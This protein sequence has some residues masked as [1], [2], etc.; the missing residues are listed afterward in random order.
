MPKTTHIYPEFEKMLSREKREELLKQHGHVFWF[1]GLSG[2]GKSTLT[3]AVQTALF[4]QGVVTE[5]LDGD[6]IRSGLNKDL[7]FTDADRLEN[8]R[9]IAEVAKLFAQ[10]GVIVLTAFITPKNE[11]RHMARELVGTKDLSEVYVKASFETCASRDPKGL[12]KKV[13]AG[14]VKNFTG[15]DS[16]FEEPAGTD[17]VLDTEALDIHQCVEQLIP[18]ILKK[19]R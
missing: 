15:K 18:F 12:Y 4:K 6:N 7:G 2:S 11:L 3:R 9:R 13:D 10:A 19:V 1:Y 17:L 14:Q 16:G 5:I 8:I